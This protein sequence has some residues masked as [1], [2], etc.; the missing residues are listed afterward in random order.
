MPDAKSQRRGNGMEEAIG[1]LVGVSDDLETDLIK[2]GLHAASSAS[3]AHYPWTIPLA[4]LAMSNIQD[5]YE[6]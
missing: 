3:P 4:P 6:D 2:S 1:R 5:C